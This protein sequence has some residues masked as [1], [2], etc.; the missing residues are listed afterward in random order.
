MAYLFILGLMFETQDFLIN[1]FD[2]FQVKLLSYT[3][4]VVVIFRVLYKSCL[5]KAH[6]DFIS[7]LTFD[8]LQF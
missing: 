2:K 7:S 4:H 1:Y 8:I 3:A 5:I 6:K